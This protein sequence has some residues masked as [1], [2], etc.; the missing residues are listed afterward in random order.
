MAAILAIPIVAA[1]YMAS[2]TTG[3]VLVGTIVVLI[4]IFICAVAPVAVTCAFAFILGG[5]PFLQPPGFPV[6]AVFVALLGVYAT[7]FLRKPQRTRL[8]V[9]EM[10]F[11][12]FIALSFVSVIATYTTRLDLTSF[13]KWSL[14]AG[15][16]FPLSR[17][18]PRQF[19]RV[20][21]AFAVGAMIGA[22]VAILSRFSLGGDSILRAV[23][24]RVGGNLTRYFVENG[25]QTAIRLAG[26]YVEPNIA[27]LFLVVG[28]FACL[29]TFRSWWRIG[30][31][32]L[33]IFA[34]SLTLSRAAIFTLIVAFVAIL[35]CQRMPAKHRALGFIAC[36]VGVVAVTALS[37]GALARRLATTG[38][39]ADRGTVERLDAYTRF[40]GLMSD[41][42]WF[43]VG[44][45]RPEFFNQEWGYMVNFVANTPLLTLYRGGLLAFAALVLSMLASL[46][47]CVVCL[48]S[49]SSEAGFV[50]AGFLAFLIVA[51]QVDFPIV[52]VPMATALYSFYL[53]M[54]IDASSDDVPRQ[55]LD[56]VIKQGGSTDS[57]ENTVG[58][59]ATIQHMSD[60]RGEH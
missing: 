34:I 60:H 2:P 35:L 12:V 42:W 55:Q 20:A 41:H 24:Y 45:G 26:P 48:R 54:L 16:V 39:D 17:F 3:L 58:R 7:A 14:A 15:V 23:G 50:G 32:V 28:F 59:S 56:R 6:P 51:V 29:R 36:V 13:I 52:I 11:Y 27:G 5:F 19:R 44:W 46:G 53:S 38:S 47:F 57:S 21:G 8:H 18:G 30:G 4:G 49:R 37:S 1:V 22:S 31:A 9:L 40:P 33:L 25:E 43:G 10:M